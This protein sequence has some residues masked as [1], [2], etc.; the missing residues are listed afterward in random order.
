MSKKHPKSFSLTEENKDFLEANM[1][2]NNSALVNDLLDAYRKN[3][4]ID[5]IVDVIERRKLERER[6][7]LEAQLE[8]VC[9]Q[10]GELEDVEE[11]EKDRREEALEALIHRVK[12]GKTIFPDHAAVQDVA[13]SY[14]GSNAYAVLEA[15]RSELDE[16]GA[17]YDAGQIEGLE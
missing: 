17:E 16:R 13:K 2:L 3:S 15:V 14:Y 9:N 7:S 8:T 12:G 10:L 5:G 11:E 4:A 1:H 6:E